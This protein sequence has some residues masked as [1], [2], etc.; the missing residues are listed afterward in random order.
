MQYYTHNHTDLE[1]AS[2]STSTTSML[3]NNPAY[4]H[5]DPHP[6]ESLPAATPVSGICSQNPAN[7]NII[8]HDTEHGVPVASTTY[9]EEPN[10]D[11]IQVDA[12]G[13]PHTV[14]GTH[15]INCSQNPAYIHL[16]VGVSDTDPAS[17]CD[18][19]Q[20]PAYGVHPN[21]K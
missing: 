15:S 14:P 7:Y 5:L 3:Q 11:V 12:D 6:M 8:H 9:R 17:T 19:S 20:N 1:E 2:P 21:P 10:Y 13:S 18:C 16:G 4:I